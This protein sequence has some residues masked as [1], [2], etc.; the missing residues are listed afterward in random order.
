[1]LI[2]AAVEMAGVIISVPRSIFIDSI[3]QY[4]RH[5]FRNKHSSF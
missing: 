2:V 1:M 3:N 5:E 4:C